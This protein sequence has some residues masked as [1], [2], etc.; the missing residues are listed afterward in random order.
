MMKRTKRLG[1]M[2]LLAAS[3]LGLSGCGGT[4]EGVRTVRISCGKPEGHPEVLGL[5]AF[6]EY[7]ESNLGDRYQVEIFADGRLGK[8]REAAELVQ[9]GAVEYAVCGAGELGCFDNVYR[10]FNL[11]YLFDGAAG[12]RTVMGEAWVT[13]WIGRESE[14]AGFRSVAW[15]GGADQAYFGQEWDGTVPDTLTVSLEFLSSLT[16]EERE[17]FDQ[18]AKASA[19]TEAAAWRK[20]AKREDQAESRLEAGEWERL[21][22][23]VLPVHDG[24]LEQYPEL[25]PVYDA[26]Q[27]IQML[28]LEE[29]EEKPATE[30]SVWD[31]YVLA[32]SLPDDF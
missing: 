27:V 15:Y 11:P 16:E 5:R 28:A 19:W 17:I 20:L 29:P 13:E 4:G 23:N 25:E 9:T 26:I 32:S 6:E 1:W 10:I 30:E 12:V 22:E 24:L 21:R 7:V 31:A 18:A 2:G 8:G 14:D 3:I